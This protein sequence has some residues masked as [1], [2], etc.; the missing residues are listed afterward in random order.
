MLQYKYSGVS[1]FSRLDWLGIAIMGISELPSEFWSIVPDAK[2]GNYGQFHEMSARGKGFKASWFPK[3]AGQAHILVEFTGEFFSQ[4]YNIDKALSLI[5]DAGGFIRIFRLDYCF[6]YYS[7][8]DFFNPVVA[9]NRK[10]SLKHYIG[11]VEY[12]SDDLPEIVDWSGFRFCKSDRAYRFYDKALEDRKRYKSDVPW[13]RY[14]VVYRGDFAHAFTND[15][16]VQHVYE[17]DIDQWGVS[18]LTFR[19]SISGIFIQDIVAA[20]KLPG[21]DIVMSQSYTVT[22]EGSRDFLLNEV[23]KRIRSFWKAHRSNYSN[24]QECLSDLYQGLVERLQLKSRDFDGPKTH[25]L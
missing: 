18:M 6:D 20:S 16:Y 21:Q 7:A 2:I 13:W 12:G 11:G 19:E 14:E 24:D 17:V 4:N 9:P 15:E 25:L 5:Y 23:S 8:V 10:K 1:C 3:I 22:F